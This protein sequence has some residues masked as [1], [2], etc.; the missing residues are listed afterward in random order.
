M[1]LQEFYTGHAFDAYTFFGAHPFAG[2]TH[3]AV[4]APAARRVQVEGPFGTQ[5]LTQ[6]RSAVWEA[7]VAQA[8]PG[9]IYQYRITGA[10][11]KT[12]AHCD[13][14][15]FAMTLRPDGRSIIAQPPQGFT[16]EA[17]MASR[18]KC[19]DRPL[20][21]YEVHA[22]SWKRKADGSWYSYAELAEQLPAYCKE[23]GFTH[24]ELM[25]LAEYPFDGS[26]GYQ[27]TGFYAPTSRYGTPAE[28]AQFINACH[29]QGI[30]VILDF[31]PVHFAVDEYGLK[32][33][34]G[35]PLYEYPA[36]A[37][38]Q[39]E[40]GSCNFMHSRGEIRCF[41]QSCADYWLRVFHA[42]GLRMDAVSRL[43]YWQG[44]PARGVNGSTL[45][46]LK[47][48]NQG[49]QQ[50]HPT[51]L[52]IAEDSSNYPKV[53]APVEYGGL[54]FDYKWDLGWMNDTLDYFKKTSDER[55]ENLGRLTFSMVYA[56]NEHYIL[57]F[58]HDENVHGKATIVQKMY[59]DYDGKFPQ[60]RA[61]YLYMAIHPGKKLD[62]MGNEFAQL[63]EW[64]ENREQDW[65]IL[66][67]PNHDAFRHFRAALNEAY[68]QNEAFWSR[69]YD[70][71]A[72]RWADCEHGEWNV[73]AILRQGRESTVLA[74]FNFGDTPHA[75][76]KL[77]LP[78][79][80]LTLLLDTDWQCWG[81]STE[82]PHRRSSVTVK[83]GKPF[84]VT[85]P[86]YSGKLYRLTLA[87]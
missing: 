27:V 10:N 48:M 41:L 5:D 4:W 24:I 26:W 3:F 37:V 62:F 54:G 73:C 15:G 72:F 38:G 35:T 29:L 79:G 52:L 13:P 39:S 33:F 59:G 78:A 74:V 50:R 51:A 69:E 22:G 57:P 66:S 87:E 49:L 60:A 1:E 17:W 86:P 83:E 11:G 20:N 32:E 61:L 44:E 70:P 34:D 65:M 30:G 18:S 75:H 36:A 45:E 47:G 56:W 21:I 85:M 80:K 58:S 2:G 7:D 43:I 63:R 9:M 81:G 71:A 23:N 31:V 46:F 84:R 8:A 77:D 12:V 16:D 42:D 67:Y 6:T 14:Y 19:F 64:D 40:W 53:T 76:Y 28:L 55:K 25:P 82:K 68:L